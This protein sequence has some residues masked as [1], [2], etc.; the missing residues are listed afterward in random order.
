[1]N[2]SHLSVSA[3]LLMTLG[4]FLLFTQCNPSENESSGNSPEPELADFMGTMQYHTHKLALSVKAS[5][6]ELSEFYLH[7]LEEATE[8]VISSIQTYEGHNIANLTESKLEP[9][10]EPV[11]EAVE[12]E[13]WQEAREQ[14]INLVSSCNSCHQ[15]TD[16]G[17]VVIEPGFDNNPYNQNFEND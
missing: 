11:H 2:Y 17:F 8:T 12:S 7:E 3:I 13:D 4:V 16:H 6:T 9:A 14:L 1:M 15:S 10:F 5:N